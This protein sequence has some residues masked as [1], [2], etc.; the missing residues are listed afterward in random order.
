MTKGKHGNK[1]AKKPKKV[2]VPNPPGLPA[3][4]APMIPNPLR[5]KK[6]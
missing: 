3:S 5:P 2:H 4:L 1:E 6:R